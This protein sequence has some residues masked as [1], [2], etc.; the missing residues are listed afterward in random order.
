MAEEPSRELR[1]TEKLVNGRVEF[2]R[3]PRCG[4]SILI[5]KPKTLFCTRCGH[6][7]ED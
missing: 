1:R 3:C 6:K 7:W 5:E 4:W 2:V